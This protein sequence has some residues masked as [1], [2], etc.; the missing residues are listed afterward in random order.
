MPDIDFS[1]LLEWIIVIGAISGAL[2]A[3][4]LL[5]IKLASGLTWV[6]KKHQT[7]VL[8]PATH[9]IEELRSKQEEILIQLKSDNNNSMRQKVNEI[10]TTLSKLE[11]DL[12]KHT[13][14]SYEQHAII[15]ERFRKYGLAG[16]D[17]DAE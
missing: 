4:I 15:D 12:E 14:W 8:A 9:E 11:G 17:S 3:F 1:P 13:K 10:H 7:A 5:A 16:P 6:G 2:T